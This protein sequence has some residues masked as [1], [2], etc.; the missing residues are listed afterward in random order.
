[1]HNTNSQLDPQSSTCSF[2][3]ML[4]EEHAEYQQYLDAQ[5]AQ[6]DADGDR[7]SPELLAREDQHML[8]SDAPADEGHMY[9]DDGDYDPSGDGDF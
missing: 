6:F 7:E 4:P 2:A 3:H 8:N 1:M 9:P 5:Q